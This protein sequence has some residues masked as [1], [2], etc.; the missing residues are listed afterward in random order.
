MAFTGMEFQVGK[1]QETSLDI[2]FRMTRGM[3]KQFA[4]SSNTSFKME[5]EFEHRGVQV[6]KLHDAALQ[7]NPGS[8]LR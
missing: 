8:A 2:I 1:V 3:W 6:E 4:L 5:I 7:G